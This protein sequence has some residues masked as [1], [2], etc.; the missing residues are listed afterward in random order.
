VHVA[1]TIR[2]SE[3]QD[4]HSDNLCNNVCD[5]IEKGEQSYLSIA[6]C[7]GAIGLTTVKYWIKYQTWRNQN[8]VVLGELL[9]AMIYTTKISKQVM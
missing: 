8:V 1:V 2:S 9:R 3:A 5:A 4:G 6:A 7:C